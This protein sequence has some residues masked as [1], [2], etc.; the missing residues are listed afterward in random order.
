MTER[1]ADAF[2]TIETI[3]FLGYEPFVRY[4]GKREVLAAKKVRGGQSK[5][6][7]ALFVKMIECADVPACKQL[8]GRYR[9]EVA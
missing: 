1:I 6:E 5:E 4:N 9:R 2:E 8:L 7:K 3:R